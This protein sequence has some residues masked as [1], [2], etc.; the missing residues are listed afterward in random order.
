MS[1]ARRLGEVILSFRGVAISQ[2]IAG[3]E[4]SLWIQAK[5]S[6]HGGRQL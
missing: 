4:N 6:M 5:N 3:Y 2:R 1:M